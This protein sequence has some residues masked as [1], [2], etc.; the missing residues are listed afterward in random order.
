MF[1]IFKRKED[2]NT[3]D[4]TKRKEIPVPKD[5]EERLKQDIA[6]V[7][8]PVETSSGGGFANFFGAPSSETPATTSSETTTTSSIAKA[9]IKAKFRDMSDK[10]SRL[11]D[12]VE[13]LEKKLDVRTR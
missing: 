7:P 11:T 9:T 10:I 2:K 1:D 4:L 6:E 13:L 12:R 3:L 8:A 5:V